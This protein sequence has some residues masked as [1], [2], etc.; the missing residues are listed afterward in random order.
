MATLYNKIFPG[1]QPCQL[2]KWR[3]NVSGT[4]SVLVFGVL[5][6]LENQSTSDVGLPEFHVHDGALANGS[7]WL[8]SS[9]L[10]QA[11]FLIGYHVYNRMPSMALQE[12]T[13]PAHPKL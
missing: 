4:I 12:A 1:Y 9:L 7:C 2:V 6:Y 5:M 10:R 11:G 8:A 13:I 3:K